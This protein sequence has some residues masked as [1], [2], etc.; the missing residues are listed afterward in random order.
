MVHD[1]GSCEYTHL[2][3]VVAAA[4]VAALTVNPSFPLLLSLSPLQTFS[5]LC[6]AVVTVVAAVAVALPRT[7]P[8]PTL[9]PATTTRL[10][11]PPMPTDSS[12][13]NL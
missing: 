7:P 9:R 13:S 8:P 2:V 10:D 12:D 11:S 1:V 5:R 6:V 4:D 3:V